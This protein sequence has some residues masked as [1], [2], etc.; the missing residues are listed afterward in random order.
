MAKTESQKVHEIYG[1][2]GERGLYVNTN[3]DLFG[4]PTKDVTILTSGYTV[5]LA[6]KET[7]SYAFYLQRLPRF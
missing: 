5:Q 6:D 3:L 1:L 7:Y 2:I 4:G